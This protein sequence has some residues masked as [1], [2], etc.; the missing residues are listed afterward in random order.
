MVLKVIS[1][2]IFFMPLFPAYLYFSKVN[3]SAIEAITIA[4]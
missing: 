2:F 3:Y 1:L 4:F